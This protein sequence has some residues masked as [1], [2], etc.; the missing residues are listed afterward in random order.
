MGLYIR[1]E[2]VYELARKVAER[3][4]RTLTDSVRAALEE[5][6]RSLEGERD[7][8]MR[9]LREIQARIAG[10][11]ELA[12]GFTDADLYDENGDPIL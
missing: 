8:K 7:A 12:P 5:R 10:L 9:K 3:E 6:W 1:D 11:P 2:G 4:R